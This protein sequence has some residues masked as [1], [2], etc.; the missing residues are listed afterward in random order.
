ML[1]IQPLLDLEHETEVLLLE[2]DHR[3]EVG[4]G[5]VVD[6]DVNG[7]ELVCGRLDDPLAVGLHG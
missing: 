4:D 1:T 2:S 6:Q 5:G 7:A 3:L